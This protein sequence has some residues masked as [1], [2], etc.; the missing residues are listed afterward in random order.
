MAPEM[1]DEACRHWYERL[2]PE[3]TTVRV[4]LAPMATLV[5]DAGWVV[6]AGAITPVPLLL[7][8]DEELELLEELDD[9]DEDELLDEED[10]ELLPEL[11][12][13]VATLMAD[14]LALV[15]PAAS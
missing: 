1:A 6:M 10:E 2:V 4:K 12:G 11:E 13:S 5:S 9:E 8:E 14:V 7:D 15:L 3:A